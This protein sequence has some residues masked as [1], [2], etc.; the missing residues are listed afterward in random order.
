MVSRLRFFER[1]TFW[2]NAFLPREGRAPPPA[3][4]FLFYQDDLSRIQVVKCAFDY[5]FSASFQVLVFQSD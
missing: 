3:F 5:E 4:L 1:T 2:V